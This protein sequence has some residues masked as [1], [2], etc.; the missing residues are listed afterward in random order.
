LCDLTKALNV[1]ND[2]ALE[3]A[4]SQ[5]EQLLVGVTPTDLRKN[6]AIRQDV[7]RNVDAILDKFNF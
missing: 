1:T 6:E 3:T 7:K 5:L 2:V 4:R